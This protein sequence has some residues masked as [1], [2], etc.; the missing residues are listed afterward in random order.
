M[1]MST[2]T[3]QA[4]LWLGT[5]DIAGYQYGVIEHSET[6]ARQALRQA[7]RSLVRRGQ[8]IDVVPRTGPGA[9]PCEYFGARLTQVSVGQV[10]SI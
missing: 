2:K 10:A 9:D 3:N 8:C 4:K 1:N 7:Y 6:A 5:I